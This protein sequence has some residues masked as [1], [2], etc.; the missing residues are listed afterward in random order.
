MIVLESLMFCYTDSIQCVHVLFFLQV[1]EKQIT[2]L[3]EK[4]LDLHEQEET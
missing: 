1:P 2:K 3:K 4:V